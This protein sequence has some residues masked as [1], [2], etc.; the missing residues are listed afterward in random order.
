MACLEL[1][2]KVTRSSILT[3]I[4]NRDEI[5]WLCHFCLLNCFYLELFN[6]F[7]YSWK[8][9]RLNIWMRD[10]GSCTLNALDNWDRVHIYINIFATRRI[11]SMNGFSMLCYVIGTIKQFHLLATICNMP[12]ILS[13]SNTFNHFIL[14]PHR[15]QNNR[16]LYLSNNRIAS[17][18]IT[19]H[20]HGFKH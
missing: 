12:L 5:Y 15:V 17:P 1:F 10:N 8:I 14:N 20:T 4:I 19:I 11:K 9:Y 18:F 16:I 13:G 6:S 2:L 7:I 3:T